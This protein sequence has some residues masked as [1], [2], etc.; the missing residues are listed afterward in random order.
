MDNN[1]KDAVKND[2]LHFE[3][4]SKLSDADVEKA[5]K[6]HN[7]EHKGG[8]QEAPKAAVPITKTTSK[9]RA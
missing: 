6:R 3:N 1:E 4:H 2:V 5:V 9:K 8:P 7:R